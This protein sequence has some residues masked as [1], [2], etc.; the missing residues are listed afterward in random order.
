MRL[1][2]ISRFPH[3][4]HTPDTIARLHILKRGIDI[5]Q[6]LP[7]RDELV[8]FQL[9]RHVIVHQV[10]ELRAAFDAAK[11]AA[12]P[13]AAS[14]E[15]EGWSGGRRVVVSEWLRLGERDKGGGAKER[16]S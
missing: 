2:F 7:V 16:G 14:H 5:L 8:D 12:F 1:H 10:R 6:R 13:Y 4:H 11:G 9:A 15:L 3:I